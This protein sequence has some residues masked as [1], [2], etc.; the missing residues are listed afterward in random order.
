MIRDI[1]LPGLKKM[2]YVVFG[3]QVVCMILCDSM[4]SDCLLS[5]YRLNC[6]IMGHICATLIEIFAWTFTTSHFIKILIS[7]YAEFKSEMA[8]H[9][10]RAPMIEC[11]TFQCRIFCYA[12][13]KSSEYIKVQIHIL[14]PP[15]YYFL[16]E[17]RKLLLI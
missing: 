17:I 12:D 2:L 7:V 3:I 4:K 6:K 14:A 11:A 13:L 10:D 5:L 8:S 15:V 1:C 9:W 16:K